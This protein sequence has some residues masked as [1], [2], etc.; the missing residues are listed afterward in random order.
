MPQPLRKLVL[1][2]LLPEHPAAIVSW[3]IKTR[4]EVDDC[5]KVETGVT[6]GS[7]LMKQIEGLGI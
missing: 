7:V 4:N 6:H 5:G 3:I 2:V 1:D